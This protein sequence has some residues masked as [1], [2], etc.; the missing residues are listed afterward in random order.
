M[1]TS[2]F[3][4]HFEVRNP[5]AWN[6]VS[7]AISAAAPNLASPWPNTAKAKAA[8]PNALIAIGA[9]KPTSKEA[10]P[11]RYPTAG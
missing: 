8:A 3:W 6:R 7:T 5:T 2:P 9:E 1:M 11:A 4:V 10:H